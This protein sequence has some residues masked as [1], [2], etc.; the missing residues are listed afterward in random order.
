MNKAV[1][2]KDKKNQELA[3]AN[4]ILLSDA[5]DGHG[6][7]KEDLKLPFV[8]IIQKLSP[9]VDKDEPEFIKGAEEGD[10]IN[11]ATNEIY[12]GDPGIFFIP[13]TYTMNYT[14]WTPRNEGGGL[15]KDYGADKSILNQTSK[16]DKNQDVLSNGNSIST[17]GLYFGFIVDLKTGFT[18]QAVIGMSSTQLK[19]SRGLNSVIQNYRMSVE[20]S[21]GPKQISPRMWYHIFKF[22][23]IPESNDQ[24]KWMGYK[25][26]RDGSIL[27]YEWGGNVY[28]EAR[29]LADS[30]AKGE[31]T[32]QSEGQE[33]KSTGKTQ[34]DNS[35]SMDD[36][37]IPF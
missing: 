27:D 9:Q 35:S 25:I 21:D 15:V 31:V 5:A 17:A 26:E 7:T 23:T 1:A 3:V 12:K 29:D 22:T 36:D 10:F 8:R 19:K 16:N 30:F 24:G 11:A 37:E 18:E 4:D 32:A 2:K 34:T 14:E 6:F 28:N 20:T 33:G 13:V